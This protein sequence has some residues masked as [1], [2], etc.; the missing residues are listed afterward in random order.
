MPATRSGTINIPRNAIA[1]KTFPAFGVIVCPLD[2]DTDLQLRGVPTADLASTLAQLKTASQAA[3][4]ATSTTTTTTDHLHG[5]SS[6]SATSSTSTSESDDSTGGSEPMSDSDFLSDSSGG[7][8][9]FDA[10]KYNASRPSA[11]PKPINTT[12]LREQGLLQ[13][14]SKG[15]ILPLFGLFNAN[16]LSSCYEVPVAQTGFSPQLK[17]VFVDPFSNSTLNLASFNLL[18]TTES[19]I[20]VALYP[21]RQCVRVMD[22]AAHLRIAYNAL[23]PFCHAPGICAM[24]PTSL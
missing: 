23:Y 13:P 12:K 3:G 19:D 14:L 24:S 11:R 18:V 21:L 9:A 7:I 16:Q 10:S 4:P 6:S 20:V 1:V 22:V 5:D 8:E 15:G 17:H 2:P